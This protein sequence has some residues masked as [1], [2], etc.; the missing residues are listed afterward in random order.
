MDTNALAAGLRRR[1]LVVA[2]GV[3]SLADAAGGDPEHSAHCRL[4]AA[5]TDNSSHSSSAMTRFQRCPS[6]RAAATTRPAAAT[7]TTTTT[8]TTTS[9]SKLGGR[10]QLAHRSS[11]MERFLTLLLPFIF[12][13]LLPTI[14]LSPRPGAFERAPMAASLSDMA[15]LGQ[16]RLLESTAGATG[17]LLMALIRLPFDK[18]RLQWSGGLVLAAETKELM[19]AK[20]D[21]QE[22]ETHMMLL[23]P[24]E[25]RSSYAPAPGG[26]HHYGGGEPSGGE[27]HGSAPT[28]G[29]DYGPDPAD[30]AAPGGEPSVAAES[31]AGAGVGQHGG[32]ASSLQARSD[33]PAV[34]ALNVKCEK[35]HMTVSHDDDDETAAATFASALTCLCGPTAGARRD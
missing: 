34:R 11:P 17:D 6:S 2:Q 7:T 3:A 32:G 27:P 16:H 19:G 23:A 8:T 5:L 22:E 14:R 13:F 28:P 35:N 10:W 20:S 21:L 4:G 18:I 9:A 29:S 15:A 12:V 33:L 24:A 31:A 30:P 25:H 1:L 26:H